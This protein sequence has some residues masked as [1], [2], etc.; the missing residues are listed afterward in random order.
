MPGEWAKYFGFNTLVIQ[1]FNASSRDFGN[2][3]SFGVQ[4]SVRS[5]CLRNLSF[6][7]TQQRHHCFFPH[8]ILLQSYDQVRFA[9]GFC[10]HHINF[11]LRIF[12][13]SQKLMMHHWRS[14]NVDEF[15]PGMYIIHRIENEEIMA[16]WVPQQFP[17]DPFTL[18]AFC[19]YLWI[20]QMTRTIFSIR[21]SNRI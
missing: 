7:K 6:V 12:A 15:R 4:N 16:F 9:V 10:S 8:V 13:K 3:P 5:W 17:Y 14:F 11:L 19:R 20:S 1:F 2:P 18:P 21:H